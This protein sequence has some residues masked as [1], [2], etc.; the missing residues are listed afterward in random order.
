MFAIRAAKIAFVAGF[1]L[2]ASLVVFGNVTD[3]GTNFEFVRHVLSMDTV[4][5]T[6]TI[7]YRAIVNPVLHHAAYLIIIVT[8]AVV[9][10]LCW[11]GAYRLVR[12]VRSE[13]RAFN[14]AKPVA[15]AG[16]TLGI[17]LWQIGFITIAGEWFGM[18]MSHQ[19]NGVPDAFRIVMILYAGLILLA[20]PDGER[21][22]PLE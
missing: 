2:H 4:F 7:A 3:Y 6:A 20:M 17:L 11:L 21:S 5:P 9:A 12:A 18:W 10:A 19:W 8:E 22:E 13:A 16:L 1:A 15:V 14:R